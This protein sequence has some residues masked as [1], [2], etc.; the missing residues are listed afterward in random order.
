MEKTSCYLFLSLY[1]FMIGCEAL[2]KWEGT[3][4]KGHCPPW[5]VYVCILPLNS[6]PP[7]LVYKWMLRTLLFSIFVYF[8]KVTNVLNMLQM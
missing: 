4:K 8:G 7:P 5:A 3:A 1:D 6:P 2:E